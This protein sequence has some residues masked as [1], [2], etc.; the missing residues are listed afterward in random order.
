[1]LRNKSTKQY[2]FFF[3]GLYH[4]SYQLQCII[5]YKIFVKVKGTFSLNLNIKGTKY[6]PLNV[7]FLRV[8]G[9]IFNL[10]T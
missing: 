9:A 2:I 5:Y 7:H 1:M 8:Y 3:L 4:G 10:L 6:V